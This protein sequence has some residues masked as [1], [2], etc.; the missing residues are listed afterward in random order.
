MRRLLQQGADD[1]SLA[2]VDPKLASFAIAG[3]LNWI[4]HWYREGRTLSAVEVA[5]VFVGLLEN[6]LAPRSPRP[7]RRSHTRK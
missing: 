7:R 4:A 3:A 2:A 1:G 6:G 5:D